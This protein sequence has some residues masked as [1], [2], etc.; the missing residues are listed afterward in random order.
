[1]NRVSINVYNVLRIIIYKMDSVKLPVQM[2]TMRI[3]T[4]IP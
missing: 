1:M 2:R 3:Q 4:N